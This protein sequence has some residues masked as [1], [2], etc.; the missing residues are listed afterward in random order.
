MQLQVHLEH[1]QFVVFDEDDEELAEQPRDTHLT[2]FFKANERYTSAH[3]ITYPQFPS[4]FT[5][6]YSQ[7]CW[8]PRKAAKT[9]GRMV[10][11]PPNAGEKF[12][13][14]L[15]LSVATDVRS[16]A[17]LRR[18]GNIQFSTYHKA[19]LARGLL[20]D[21]NKWKRTLEDGTHMQTGHQLRQ[22][23]IT[24]VTYNQPSRPAKLWDLFKVHLC[25]DLSHFL[26]LQ[27]LDQIN[28]EMVFDYGL[29]LLQTRLQRDDKMMVSVG[30]PNPQCNWASLLS[31]TL[32]PH[33]TVYDHAEQSRL[34]NDTLPHLNDKQLHA[35]TCILDSAISHSPCT[36]F[37]QRAAGAGKT[38][39]YNT[40]CFDA[41]SQDLRVLCVASSGIAALLLP[42]GRTA[43]SMLK[44]PLDI[45][46]SSTCS[47]SKR[48]VL[49]TALKQT[50]LL[51]WD[52]CSMQNCFAFE[53]V[54]RTLQDICENGALF[55]GVTA[56]LGGDFLQTLP[57]VTG[58]YDTELDTLDAALLS[59]SL[60]PAI[61][62]HFLKLE[63]NMHV[64]DDSE[65]QEFAH[66]QRLL[67]KGELNNAED[68]VLIPEKFRCTN[69]NLH[70]LVAGTY[71]DIVQPHGI[72]YFHE[73]CI[74]A[75]Q[76]RET[77]EINDLLP[78]MFP[79]D[80]YDLWS[81]DKAFDPD[82]PSHL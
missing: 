40:L 71:P 35:F 30:L 57:V 65:E 52:E 55:G 58:S 53:A 56:I 48:S 25:I 16:F 10:F 67:A 70:S 17:G 59:S 72:Q 63:R 9:S 47:I 4:K 14:C 21:D 32:S 42:G 43:H 1:E 26:A 78:N 46:Q 36:F 54:D 45:D 3:T 77:H 44:I 82:N 61:L 49:A 64:G 79:G 11:V 73:C 27:R 39:V 19:C 29:H 80:V 74:L 33:Q 37:L 24:I 13:A 12:Y 51:I 81:I 8:Y 31:T 50:H 62:P 28:D 69:N 75:P 18:V 23:F 6:N 15:L 7:K 22:L 5:W 41:R 76:N 20:A 2:A 38:F 34:L 60:W 68:Y 66:W